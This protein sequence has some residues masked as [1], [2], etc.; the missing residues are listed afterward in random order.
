MPTEGRDNDEQ[1]WGCGGGGREDSSGASWPETPAEHTSKAV[2]K[3]EVDFWRK[4][5]FHPQASLKPQRLEREASYAEVKHFCE[6]LGAFLHSY[7][8]Y[9]PASL[10]PVCVTY[11]DQ[12]LVL[13]T[14][15]IFISWNIFPKLACICNSKHVRFEHRSSIPVLFAANWFRKLENERSEAVPKYISSQH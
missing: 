9:N 12:L 14:G 7:D 15:A 6:C 10:E 13:F 11:C 3:P 4:S 5:K 8:L 2:E 1:V